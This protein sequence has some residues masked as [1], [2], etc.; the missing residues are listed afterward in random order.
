[1]AEPV[2]IIILGT[3]GN[4]LDILDCLMEINVR[5]PEPLYECLGFLDDDQD[6]RGLEIWGYKVL[7]PLSQAGHFPGCRFVNG[8][9]SPFS[10]RRK[11]DIIART[12]LTLDRFETVIHPAASVSRMAELGRDVVVLQNAVI[13]AE[14]QIGH[15][16]IILP[17]SVI[18]HGAR[19]GDYACIAGGV[20]LAGAVEIGERCYLG[21]NSCVRG[22]VNIGAGSLVG[23]GGVVLQDIPQNSVVVGNPARFLRTARFVYSSK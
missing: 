14:V 10:Y 1:M 20:N 4:C 15:H 11:P 6:K 3:G 18:S 7:G 19:I 2:K 23:M 5:R 22:Q 17:N 12:G 9:G 16:V 8:I 21:A 13:A